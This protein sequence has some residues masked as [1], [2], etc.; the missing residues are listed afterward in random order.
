MSRKHGIHP[1][2]SAVDT[3]PSCDCKQMFYVTDTLFNVSVHLPSCVGGKSCRVLQ[4]EEERRQQ[5]TEQL[6]QI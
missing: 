4:E 6:Q 1:Y 3:N 5:M 2:N